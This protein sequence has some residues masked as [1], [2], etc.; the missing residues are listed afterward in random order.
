MNLT[1]TMSK[2][3]YRVSPHQV[4]LQQD[5]V[6]RLRAR[7]VTL[8]FITRFFPNAHPGL[9]VEASGLLAG[10]QWTVT[11]S[12]PDVSLAMNIYAQRKAGI[13]KIRASPTSHY[14]HP[15][16]PY[17]LSLVTRVSLACHTRFAFASARKTKRL[18]R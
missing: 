2:R 5:L 7:Y 11:A 14:F 8:K 17:A 4:L 10:N 6:K 12:Y 1:Q 3:K 16:V 18:R 13:R 9:P 15:M